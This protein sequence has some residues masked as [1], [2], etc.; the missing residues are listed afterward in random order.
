MTGHVVAL[1]PPGSGARARGWRRFVPR[2]AHTIAGWLVFLATIVCCWTGFVDADEELY[3]LGSRRLADPSLL[4]VDLTWSK[5]SPTTALYDH[6]IAPLWSF[7]DAFAIVNLGRL[8]FWGLMAWALARLA[9]TIR[10][11]AWSLVVGFTL[12]LLWKQSLGTCGSPYQGF[13]PKS[14]AYPLI[15]LSLT[16]AIRG[17][18]GRAGLAAGLATAFHII[19]GGWACLGLFLAMLV[20]RRLFTFRQ[21]ALY[22]AATVPFVV[23]LVLSVVLFH[24]GHVTAADQHRMNDVYALFAMPHCCDPATFMAANHIPLAWPRAG[25][26]FALSLVVVFAWRERR[27]AAILGTFT[28]ALIAFFT[29]GLVAGRFGMTGLLT[30]YPFQLANALPALFLFVFVAGWIGTGGWTRRFGW[31]LALPVLAGT[32][33]LMIDGDVP[34][35]IVE[36]PVSFADEVKLLPELSPTLTELD[37]LYD[38]IRASTPRNSVFITPLIYEFWPYAERAQVASMRQ[39][40]LDRAILD[41][42]DRLD[43]LNQHV[44]YRQRGFEIETELAAHESALSVAE[45]N[46]MRVRYGATHYLVHGERRDLAG[47]LVHAQQGYS[48]YDLARLGPTGLGPAGTRGN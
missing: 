38:W 13:Q 3:L 22:L 19:V 43:A 34:S 31:A 44:P 16:E 14:F 15:F 40:P 36:R 30:L 7:M 46:E 26:V 47:L 42:K 27:A 45:L 1:D 35:E 20:Q 12:W 2:D 37:P 10:L 25:V 24:S 6:M 8:L 11:P 33:W 41:W 21:L 28:A 23:P 29:L 9:R 18:A 5:L 32:L 4:A 17:R 48:I 39:P